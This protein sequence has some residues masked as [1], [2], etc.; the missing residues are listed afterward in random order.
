LL[1][2]SFLTGYL[3][4]RGDPIGARVLPLG[5]PAGQSG[6]PARQAPPAQD[7][8]PADLGHELSTFWETWNFVEQS[9]YR[10]PVERLL[11]AQGAI[12]GLL[13]ALNDPHGSYLDPQATRAE[14]AHLDGIVEG[15]GSTV[16]LKER[17]YT[18]LAPIEDG[19][20]SR[21]GLR[22]GDVILKVDGRDI[23]QAS[24]AEAVAQLRGPSGTKVRLTVQRP[25]EPEGQ[26]VEVEL[27]RARL[28]LEAVTWRMAADG[29]G[30]IR[31]RVFGSQT[32]PQLTR[33]L[34]EMRSRRV[35]GIVLDLRDNPGGYLTT[36]AEVASQ[37]VKDGKVVFYEEQLGQRRPTLTRPGGLGTDLTV[38]V[39][40][41]RGTAS[42]SE[43]VAAALRDQDRGVLIGENTFGKGSVQ[44]LHDL[45]DGSAVRLTTG[46]WL[47]P[48]GKS[49]E[50]PGLVPSVAARPTADDERAKRDVALEKALEWFKV[51]P[52]DPGVP[53]G[54]AGAPAG[55]ATEPPPDDAAPAT[56][57]G[58]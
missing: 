1:V 40:V 15:I 5:A 51:A 43:M 9:Y 35:R 20:A 2:V 6:G 13:Q 48:N 56:A 54:A 37:F 10:R 4:G 17:R 36:A 46:T 58:G 33:A 8:A 57:T 44:Q 16:E 45:S 7:S 28:E 31:I 41:N 49:V 19:P 27:T 24:L 55:G 25:D 50:G 52:P 29:I 38:A 39:L 22:T 12:K 34:R 30:Y 11:L 47:T 32:V 14:K 53:P 21:A 3:V 23:G 26:P 18:V 42:A